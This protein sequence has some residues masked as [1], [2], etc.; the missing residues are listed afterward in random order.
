MT[1]PK[2]L[3]DVLLH[4]LK[5]LYSAE[6]QLLKALPK[7]EK[8]A[9][10]EQL[11][12][13]FRSHL[14][15][16]KGQVDRLEQISGLLKEKLSGKT[17]KGMQGLIEE[18]KE[19]LEEESEN[20]ALIDAM[21]IGAA[22]RVEHYEIAGYG[23]ACALA[24]QLGEDSVVA[25]LAQTLGEESEADEKLSGIAVDQVLPEAH[26]EAGKKKARDDDDSDKRGGRSPNR[27][28]HAE[29]SRNGGS[30]SF[31]AIAGALLVSGASFLGADLAVAENQAQTLTKEREA[32]TH[33][34]D[35][36]GRNARDN[37]EFRK[38][39]DGQD[40]SSNETE[41]LAKIRREIT[42][43]DDLSTYAKNVKIMVESGEVTLRG[44]VR[45]AN[46]RQWIEQA[47]AR[48]APSFKVV[49]QLEIAPS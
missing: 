5:D 13:A 33:E 16:T 37:N 25:L 14:E 26:D 11:K 29:S 1:S 36:T 48:I 42:S 43:N 46:E 10:S 47:A 35:N 40:L 20:A 44:P 12:E 30:R 34:V 6:N 8:K 27:P 23:S 2:S 41:V 38:T 9:S 7:M 18:G 4:E 17:C 49:N 15:E 3:R 31:K 28:M 21:L 45:S 39:P 22:Q 24:E 19:I 32:A